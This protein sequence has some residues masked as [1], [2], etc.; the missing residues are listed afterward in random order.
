[1]S[2]LDIKPT[3]PLLDRIKNKETATKKKSR[4]QK[5]R[6]AIGRKAKPKKK[7]KK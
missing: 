4:F 6:T 1:M 5:I 3:T 7:H 2:A